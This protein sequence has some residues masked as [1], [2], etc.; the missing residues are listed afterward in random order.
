MALF[1]DRN[2]ESPYPIRERLF[3]PLTRVRPELT[4][5]IREVEV[6][7]RKVII[8]R[9]RK[10]VAALVAHDLFE[11]FWTW[12]EDWVWG[13]VDPKTDK[14]LGLNWQKKPE[15]AHLLPPAEP[16]SVSTAKPGWRRWLGR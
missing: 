14:R 13:P 7:G 8:R 10:P 4:Q 1:Y 9:H 15:Y 12:D 16:L 6:N 11:L 3:I 2:A 5:L